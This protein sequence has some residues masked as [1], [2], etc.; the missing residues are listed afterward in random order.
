VGTRDRGSDAPVDFELPRAAIAE[1]IVNA[2]AHRDYSSRAAVQ[3]MVFSDRIEVWNPGE[4]P[5]GL[6]PEL[7]HQPHPSIPRNPLIA[8][9]LFLAHY[10]EKAG[11]GT[12]DMVALCREAGLPEPEFTQRGNQFVVTIWRD[13]LTDA[14]MDQLG[15]N[16]RQRK[17]VVLAKQRGRVTNKEYK[18][19]TGVTDRT[20]LRDL[21]DLLNKGVFYKVGTTGRGTHYVIKRGTRQEP[22]KPDIANAPNTPSGTPQHER[23]QRGH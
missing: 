13:W 15:L 6:T 18:Q 17:G 5:P 23:A 22:D 8:E 3:V 10:I 21:E 20:A 11:T 1:A 16:D 9:P 19:A 12:L 14:V 7:L 2:V 4:L